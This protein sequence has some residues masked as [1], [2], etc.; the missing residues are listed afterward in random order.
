MKPTTAQAGG[1]TLSGS[2]YVFLGEALIFPTGLITTAF[3]TRQLGPADYGLFTLAST[4][5]AWVQW[6]ITSIFA[7]ATIKFVGEVDDWRPIGTTVMR[8][9]LLVS[10]SVML[11]VWLLAIPIAELMGEPQLAVYLWLFSLDIPLFSL[12]GGHRDILVGIGDFKQRAISAAARWIARMLLIV[13]LVSL[14]LSVTGAILGSIG[15]SLV[16]LIV[17]RLAVQPSFFGRVSVPLRQVISYAAPLFLFA[18]TMRLYDKVDLFALKILGG[19][20]EQAGHYGAAQNL[21]LVPGIF[22]LS[23][24]PL[25]LSTLTRTLRSDDFEGAREI[26]RNALRLVL[27]LLPFAAM[28]AGA[29]HEIVRFIFGPEFQ[30]TASLL[31]I[32]IF[33]SLALV[34]ISVTTAILTAAGKPGWTFALTGPMLLV[35]LIAH[36][37]FIPLFGPIGAVIVTSIVAG[38]G[39]LATCV[40]VYR[41]WRILPPLGTLARTLLVSGVI[42]AFAMMWPTPGTLVALKI[43]VTSAL[44]PLLFIL[45]GELS[46]GERSMI[47]SM[48]RRRLSARRVLAR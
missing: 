23:F 22:A 17:C 29:A 10:C 48:I 3:L 45:L 12:T 15:A 24:S 47:V 13:L 40:A 21:A 42:Y 20:A 19:T 11:L 31:A 14:G 30:D 35:A 32:L 1:R 36:F 6:T 28:T 2:L 39:A 46:A 4:L 44:I 8:M 34:M 37:A 25:L 7:R 38:V 5:I 9:H 26:G 18:I 27:M 43:V 33:G 41:L 16:Q